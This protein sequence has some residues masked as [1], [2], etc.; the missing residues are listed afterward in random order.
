MKNNL[1]LLL[2]IFFLYGV[3]LAQSPSKELVFRNQYLNVCDDITICEGESVQLWAEG[4]SFYEW[5]PIIGLSNTHISNPMASPINTI[6]YYITGYYSGENVVENGN[7]N[8]GNTGFTTQYTH[9]SNLWGEGT[10]F[11]GADASNY[12]SNFVG[13]DHTTGNGN[14]MIINGYPGTNVTIWSQVIQ[15]SPNTEYSFSTWV[16]TLAGN[17]DEVAQL[18]FSINGTQIGEIFPAPPSYNV[19]QQFYQIWNS[20]DATEATITILN[21]NTL[22]SGNDFGLDDISFVPVIGEQ[23]SVTVTV[24]NTTGSFCYD[25]ACFGFPYNEY[26]F[27]IPNPTL[28][29]SNHY[30]TFESYTGCDSVVVLG[31]TT[32]AVEDTSFSDTV[33]AYEI[34]EE[35]G[36][37]FVATHDT[38]ISQIV[39]TNNICNSTTLNLTVFPSYTVDTSITICTGETYSG[40]GFEN[41]SESDIYTRQAQTVAGCDS[42]IILRLTVTNPTIFNISGG[43]ASCSESDVN[44]FSILMDDSEEGVTYS[45]FC[46][47]VLVAT[48]AG[49]GEEMILGTF[50]QQGVYTVQGSINDQC[51]EQMNGVAIIKSIPTP[52]ERIIYHD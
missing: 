45:V 16:C 21:Q 46:N 28:G 18:Q 22:Q 8:A 1:C 5:F 39:H 34:Y 33:C 4:V 13:H 52:P 29:T 17:P 32:F 42:S 3:I 25:T 6:T 48:V 26:G 30:L 19:W 12:H 37:N 15:V 50:T 49:T 51:S 40:F 43:G 11:V 20:G 14:F 2:T 23:D 36:F 24:I 31:L 44:E 27:N 38:V 35:H 7:F 9:N 47:Q 10:Y 41:L